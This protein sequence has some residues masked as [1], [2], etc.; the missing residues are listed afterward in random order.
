MRRWFYGSGLA[1]AA[2]LVAQGAPLAGQTIDITE[3]PFNEQTLRPYGQPVVP[4]FEG[5]YETPEGK[6]RICFGYLN[7][8]TVESV[9]IPLGENNRLEP[10]EW[11]G[12]QPTHFRPVPETS[13]RRDY[14][15]FTIEVGDDFGPDDRIVW[16]LQS[17]GGP[18]SAPGHVKPAYET[19][20]LVTSGRGD[21]APEIRFTPDGPAAVG[22]TGMTAEVVTARVGEPLELSVW[23]K[24]PT[25][26]SWVIWAA[27]QA[28]GEV[29]FSESQGRVDEVE[30]KATTTATFSEPGEYL[31]RIQSINSLGS[32]DFY[33]CW[34]NAYLPVNVVK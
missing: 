30:G 32:F 15:V 31:L 21:V 1:L 16:T 10:A 25:P 24:H 8:N 13:Y 18:L 19:D 6:K 23:V 4:V 12:V 28:P 2:L 7:P 22:R 11:D 5:W 26:R 3:R 9:D 29:M 27:H 14:C 17:R 34:T 20:N 33:C